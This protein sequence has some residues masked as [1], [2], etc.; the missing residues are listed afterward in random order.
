MI[1]IFLFKSESLTGSLE[2]LKHY[3]QWVKTR[4]LWAFTRVKLFKG[5]LQ[6]SSAVVP[7][8]VVPAPFDS[9]R[10]LYYISWT[11]LHWPPPVL[12]TT[13]A[14]TNHFMLIPGTTTSPTSSCT[15]SNIL[16][17]YLHP[18]CHAR[19]MSS[20]QYFYIYTTWACNLNWTS[21]GGKF[22]CDMFQK[23]EGQS[24]T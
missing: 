3:A 8:V 11:P 1:T 4:A 19:T 2:S 18:C 6:M 24:S 9:A 20:R 22:F 17:L 23:T 13:S 16:P 10:P 7:L 12:L 15:T 14:S 21:E 5:M